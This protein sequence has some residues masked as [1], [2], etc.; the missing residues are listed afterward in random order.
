M[1]KITVSECGYKLPIGVLSTN[2]KGLVRD[3]TLR[4]YKSS[5]DRHIAD[6]V[7]TNESKY[8]RP[9]TLIAARVSKFVSLICSQVGDV[10]WALD[11]D[12]NSTPEQELAVYGM[13]YADVM[14]VY[15]MARIA[16]LGKDYEYPYIC[17]DKKCAAN[18]GSKITFDLSTAD[19]DILE[20]NDPLQKWVE[21]KFPFKNRAGRLV[22]KFRIEP[23][24]WHI[25]LQPDFYGKSADGVS[26]TILQDCVRGIDGQDGR[27]ELTTDE[28]DEINHADVINIDRQTKSLAPGIDLQTKIECICGRLIVNPLN[29]TPDFFFG[30][31]YPISEISNVSETTSTV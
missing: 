28:I 18:K 4:P 13:W 24:R 12:K 3:F 5:V 20:P 25:T 27:Y 8:S 31:S 10:A 23:A 7:E 15:F 19:V 29:W 30:S 9:G 6:W 14:Y 26:Y 17:P 22:K 11:K 1:K 16:S 21:L 2:G